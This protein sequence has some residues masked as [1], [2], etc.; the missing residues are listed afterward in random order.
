MLLLEKR[1]TVHTATELRVLVAEMDKDHNH[2][3]SFLELACAIFHK[4]FDELN[5]FVDESARKA[6]LEQVDNVISLE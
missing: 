4:P 5:N 2:L 1:G 3:I 6:A